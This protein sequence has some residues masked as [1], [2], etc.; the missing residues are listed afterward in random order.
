MKPGF[1]VP[2]NWVVSLLKESVETTQIFCLAEYHGAVAWSPLFRGA[3]FLA[4]KIQSSVENDV[5][6][7]C[8]GRRSLSLLG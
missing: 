2:Q 6:V 5:V 3:G 7:V 4:P 8:D 1:V